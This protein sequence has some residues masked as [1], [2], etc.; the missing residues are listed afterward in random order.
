MKGRRS[1]KTR[2]T[3]SITIIV[4]MFFSGIFSFVYGQ[5]S[6]RNL[7]SI[8]VHNLSNESLNLPLIHENRISGF[9]LSKDSLFIEL[10]SSNVPVNSRDGKVTVLDQPLTHR[11]VV[12]EPEEKTKYFILNNKIQLSNINVIVIREEKECYT[13]NKIKKNCF[14]PVQ[15]AWTCSP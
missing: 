15:L 10:L 9:C 6:N 4:V 3:F 13:L 11:K 12:L 8:R 5:S 2:Y 14:K 7:L 1:K